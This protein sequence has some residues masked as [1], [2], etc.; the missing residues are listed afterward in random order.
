MSVA[1]ALGAKTPL[2][3]DLAAGVEA[4]SSNQTV[5]FTKYVKLVLPLDGYIFWVKADLVSAGALANAFAANYA[6]PGE[7]PSVATPAPTFDAPGSLHYAT[8]NQQTVEGNYE[9]NRVVFTSQGPI[10]EFYQVGAT[11]LWIGEFQGKKFAFS[12][13]KSFYQQAGLHH[14]VGD[15]V[16]P[17]MESQLIDKLD[18]FSQALIVSNS[19]PIWLAMNNVAA[20]P[21]Q[22][23]GAP[24]RL[25]PAMLSP[26]NL[27]P[28]FCTVDVID[29]SGSAIAM[30]P[31]LG[32]RLEHTQLVKERV[33]ITLWGLDNAGAMNFVDFVNQYSLDTNLFGVS[34]MP[35][36]RDVKQKQV[37]L[38]VIGK[39]KHV[40]YEINY[41]QR[42]ARDVA[43]QLILKAVPSFIL[44][45]Q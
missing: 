31:H 28:P 21:W 35:A 43:R 44:K 7:P 12:S 45:D 5:K 15:A 22:L 37:E 34:N 29:G 39:K 30:A 11:V 6:A 33:R 17:I 3:S 19:L 26:E 27:T 16:Y 13:R 23:F 24:P 18:G 9:I 8:D 40:E 41:N 32:R 1:E 42:A 38:G 36:A 4:I 2:A 20:E 14:Y 10:N 25:Y